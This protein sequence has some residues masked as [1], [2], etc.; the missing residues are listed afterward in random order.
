[1]MRRLLRNYGSLSTMRLL[2]TTH[3]TFVS[4]LLVTAFKTFFN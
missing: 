1:M 4:L 2:S 3:P